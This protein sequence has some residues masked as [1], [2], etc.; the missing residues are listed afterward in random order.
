M[1]KVSL[2]G[3]SIRIKKSR[4]EDY[5]DLYRF[6]GSNDIFDVFKDYFSTHGTKG[7]NSQYAVEDVPNTDKKTILIERARDAG[8]RMLEGVIRIGDYGYKTPIVNHQSKQLSYARDTEDTE[9]SPLYFLLYVPQK[10]NIP[11]E[12]MGIAVFQRFRKNGLKTVFIAHFSSYFEQRFPDYKVEMFSL[13]PG[14]IID[15]LNN[16]VIKK[17]QL[18][19]HSPPKDLADYYSTNDEDKGKLVLAFEKGSFHRRFIDKLKEIIDH[20]LSIKKII[21]SDWISPDEIKVLVEINGTEKTFTIKEEGTEITP[22]IDIS[23]SV[24]IGADGFP[25][26]RSLHNEAVEYVKLLKSYL[27]GH[28]EH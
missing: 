15:A 28:N 25:T 14:E 9:L 20:D 8:P 1:A 10:G 17:V 27:R 2:F 13:A 3:Y 7:S 6:D 5:L 16:G 26:E 18:I 19:S 24:T 12:K 22:G 23:D 11:F 21:E 4:T